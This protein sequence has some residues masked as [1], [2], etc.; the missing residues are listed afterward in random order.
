MPHCFL[1][2]PMLYHMLLYIAVRKHICDVA[3]HICRDIDGQRGGESLSACICVRNTF[4]MS[5]CIC[6][7]STL[8]VCRGS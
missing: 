2:V 5:A 1:D 6:V 3:G 8:H 7:R 4:E